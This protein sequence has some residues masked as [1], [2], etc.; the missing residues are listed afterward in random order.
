MWVTFITFCLV[1]NLAVS[2]IIPAAI[3]FF[4]EMTEKIEQSNAI[5]NEQEKDDQS[6]SFEKTEI[7]SKTL[8][9]ITTASMYIGVFVIIFGTFSLLLGF[10]HEDGERLSNA[11]PMITVGAILVGLKTIIPILIPT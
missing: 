5:T 3:T 8:S 2:A 1:L 7:L 4:P 11:I 10:V 9:I 6:V